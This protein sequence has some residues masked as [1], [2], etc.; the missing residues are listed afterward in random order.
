MK[1]I[2]LHIDGM[3]CGHCLNAVRQALSDAAGI[4]VESVQMGRAVVSYDAQ[5]TAPSNIE[6][7]IADAGY[8]ATAVPA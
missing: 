4:Q 5:L 7:L 3:S 8:S 2:T 1:R 6:S